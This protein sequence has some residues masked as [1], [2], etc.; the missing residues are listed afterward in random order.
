MAE[1]EPKS[2]LERLEAGTFYQ[3]EVDA[4]REIGGEAAAQGLIKRLRA[5]GIETT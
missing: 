1:Q 2:M 5:Q 4:L 3:D